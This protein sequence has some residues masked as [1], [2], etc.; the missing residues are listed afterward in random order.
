[1][2][3]Q[4]WLGALKSMIYVWSLVEADHQNQVERHNSSRPT[5]K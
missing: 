1:M 5:P 3:A 2:L 4:I